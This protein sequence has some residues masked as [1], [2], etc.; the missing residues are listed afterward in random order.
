MRRVSLFLALLLGSFCA[1]APANACTISATGVAF[2]AYN[3][4]SPTA[5]TGVGS[6]RLDC[7]ANARPV[8]AI[9]TGTSGT[10][11][12]RRMTSGGYSLY[13]NLYTTSS[14]SS[15]WGDGT[16]GS[17]TVAAPRRASTTTVH[18]QISAGQ[19][20]AAGSYSDTLIVTVTF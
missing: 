20:V 11:T 18:G 12:Q 2:G 1:A 6:V 9:G 10:F 3:P 8:I 4:R 7:P 16:G 19:N 15:V 13:Y 14:L 5:K 17:V